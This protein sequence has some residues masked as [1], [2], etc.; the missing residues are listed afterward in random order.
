MTNYSHQIIN[1]TNIFWSGKLHTHS[2]A[3]NPSYYQGK[4]KCHLSLFCFLEAKLAPSSVS[5]GDI[6]GENPLLPNYEII[7]YINKERERVG[8]SKNG[9]S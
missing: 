2:W 5:N 4:R 7:K 3:L 1:N 8:N 9:T 6:Q